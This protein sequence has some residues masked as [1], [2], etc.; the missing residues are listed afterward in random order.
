MSI[1]LEIGQFP[2]GEL[3][4]I[5]GRK[6]CEQRF[7]GNSMSISLQLEPIL[8][9]GIHKIPAFAL[10]DSEISRML[11]DFLDQF[12]F[13]EDKPTALR[14]EHL[15]Q[16]RL[17]QQKFSLIYP[18]AKTETIETTFGTTEYYISFA[19]GWVDW[20]AYWTEYSLEHYKKPGFRW[21]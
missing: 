17:I 3:E 9:L 8:G 16:V 15:E 19:K 11:R 1:V 4:E 10:I 7:S 2:A 18:N 12:E 14:R 21:G 5:E 6:N 20:I 13:Q